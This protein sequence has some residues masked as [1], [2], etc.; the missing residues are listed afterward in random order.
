MGA[1]KIYPCSSVK[2][3]AIIKQ[4]PFSKKVINMKHYQLKVAK[5]LTFSNLINKNFV[6]QF[7]C[8]QN[9]QTFQIANSFSFFVV[10]F[11]FLRNGKFQTN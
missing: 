7:F 4:H 11:L 8:W 5:K 1:P 2:L 6:S 3:G 10:K 9:A